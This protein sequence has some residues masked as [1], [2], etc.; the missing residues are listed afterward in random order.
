M[1]SKNSR[2]VPNPKSSSWKANLLLALLVF[3]VPLGVKLILQSAL[4]ASSE[5]VKS[6][7][8]MVVPRAGHTATMLTN[9]TVL[10]TG[11]TNLAGESIDTPEVFDPATG[12][13]HVPTSDELAVMQPVVTP[14][15]VSGP[16]GYDTGVDLVN[17]SALFFGLE[18]AGL[19]LGTNE[20]IVPLTDTNSGAL[21]RVSASVTELP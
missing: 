7:E 3:G 15:P 18:G 20:T 2:P 4:A 17:G 8:P 12:K 6:S 14:G 19:T 1:N 21:Y 10:I 5:Q 11:G 9:G 13:F 16:P